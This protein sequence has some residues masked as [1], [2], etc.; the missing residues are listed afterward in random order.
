MK[1]MTM[2]DCRCYGKET[3]SERTVYRLH[4]DGLEAIVVHH[5]RRHEM[6]AYRE[7]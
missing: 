6:T 2:A 1:T 5:R 7:E 4:L 3:D